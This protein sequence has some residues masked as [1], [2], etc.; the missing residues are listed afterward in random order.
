[1]NN[2]VAIIDYGVGNLRSVLQAIHFLNVEAEVVSDPQLLFGFTHLILPGVGSFRRAMIS[3]R[4]RN[5]D[6]ILLQQVMGGTPILGI[7]LGM[8]L[9]ATRSS[10][11]GESLGLGLIPGD[12]DRFCFDPASVGLK[13]PHVGFDTVKP[14][15]HSRLFDGLG[16]EIDFYF[17]HSYR[18]RCKQDCDIAASSQYGE[19]Y[20]AAVQHGIVAG[21]QFHPEKSQSN[22][23]RLLSNFFKYF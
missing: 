8:Q 12:V 5:L 19:C 17:T 6:H 13:I 21:T 16:T 9:L 23:L 11:D 18:L 22:G 15:P 20:V 7:C 10:E 4:E 1:M 2:R 14:R 3:I